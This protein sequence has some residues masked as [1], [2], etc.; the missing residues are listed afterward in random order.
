MKKVKVV[1]HVGK[2]TVTDTVEAE[3]IDDAV[4]NL[5][6]MA[7]MGDYI[8]VNRGAGYVILIPNRSITVVTVEEEPEA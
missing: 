5:Y 1:Y 8:R 7:G 2:E 6:L 3:C 4:L